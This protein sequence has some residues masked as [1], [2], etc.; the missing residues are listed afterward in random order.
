MQDKNNNRL[1]RSITADE[2]YWDYIE[3]EDIKPKAFDL[4]ASIFAYLVEN[5]QYPEGLN[6]KISN[7]QNRDFYFCKDIHFTKQITQLETIIDIVNDIV[8]NLSEDY[9]HVTR[10]LVSLYYL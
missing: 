8:D 4:A 10:I 9:N 5:E 1:T 7:N 2:K 6:F 3:S